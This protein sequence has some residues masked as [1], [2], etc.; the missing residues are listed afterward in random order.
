MLRMKTCPKCGG[1]GRVGHI[2]VTSYR[3]RL[4]RNPE[5]E[6]DEPCGRCNESGEIPNPSARDLEVLAEMIA[7]PDPT[8]MREDEAA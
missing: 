7:A 6:V 2:P 1:T 4:E 3:G 5:H 8:A